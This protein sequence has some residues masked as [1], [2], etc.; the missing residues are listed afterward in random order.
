MRNLLLHTCCCPCA[1]HPLEQLINQ[2]YNLTLFYYNPNIQ[3]ANEY[4][5]RLNELIKYLKKWPGVRL[6]EG[7]YEINKWIELTKGMGREPEGGK[8][9]DI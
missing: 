3:P 8:R 9:C 1:C 6:V 2:G 5:A 7:E 4:S